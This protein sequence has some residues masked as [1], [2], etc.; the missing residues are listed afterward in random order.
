MR[1]NNWRFVRTDGSTDAIAHCVS[2]CLTMNRGITLQFRNKFN[3]IDI[4]I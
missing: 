4:L 3:N 1:G 2:E